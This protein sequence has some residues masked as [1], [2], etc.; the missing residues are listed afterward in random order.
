MG[1]IFSL[2]VGF[3]A[4]LALVGGTPP[5]SAEPTQPAVASALHWRM[6][7]PF[8]GGRTAAV[9]GIPSQP[10]VFFIAAVNG[11]IWKTTDYGQTWAPIFDGQPSGSVGTIAIAPSNPQVMY[12]GS[13]EGLQRPDL[14]TG[15]GMYKSIDGGATWTHLGLRDGQQ[16]AK[17][18]VDPKDPN[19]LYVAVLG[20]PYGPNTERG[21]YRSADGGATFERVL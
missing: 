4:A 20:H 15:D 5:A 12:A 14:S 21:V 3:L 19:R 17:I 13:G 11:G 10:N 8:R 9:T 16:I 6:I 1:R 18:V 2:A 7:G